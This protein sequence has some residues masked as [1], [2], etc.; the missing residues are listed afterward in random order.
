MW[1][2]DG[3]LIILGN[4]AVAAW[5]AQQE[6]L[7]WLSVAGLLLCWTWSH[8]QQIMHDAQLTA[9]IKTLSSPECCFSGC[10]LRSAADAR[11][12][13]GG[14]RLA[15]GGAAAVSAVLSWYVD[16]VEVRVLW[17]CTVGL[18]LA[19]CIP[20][21]VTLFQCAAAE[22]E[23]KQVHRFRATVAI[24]MLHDVL[25]GGFWLYLATTLDNMENDSEWCKILLSMISWHILVLILR[26]F[27]VFHT[28]SHK[29]QPCCGPGAQPAWWRALQ[30]LAFMVLYLVIVE[31]VR[32]HQLRD[33][34]CT[35]AAAVAAGLALTA[36]VCSRRSLLT[37]TSKRH[38]RARRAPTPPEKGSLLAF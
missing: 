3:L 11:R 2:S 5:C 33:M 16:H 1:V 36:L 21:I 12:W 29:T 35:A 13:T 18:W 25:L 19:S 14:L 28:S 22:S 38:V 9:M 26:T 37:N 20:M 17:S 32:Q 7:W 8:V 27:F 10:A 23:N 15:A 24:W 6:G 31:R 34:G 4:V 30:F